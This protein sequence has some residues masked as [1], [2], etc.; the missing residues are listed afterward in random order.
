MA[1]CDNVKPER[2]NKI[3]RPMDDMSR[4]AVS[5]EIGEGAFDY[6]FT[7]RTNNNILRSFTGCMVRARVDYRYIIHLYCDIFHPT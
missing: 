7:W 5:R 1:F 4:L 6:K 2:W 3:L